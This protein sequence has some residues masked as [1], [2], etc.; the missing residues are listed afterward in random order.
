MSVSYHGLEGRMWAR[1]WPGDQN[2]HVV[3]SGVRVTLGV[4]V[5]LPSAETGQSGV[6]MV[7]DLQPFLQHRA[8]LGFQNHAAFCHRNFRESGISS[9]GC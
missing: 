9:P 3:V 6:G 1:H 5:F 4:E 8:G 7:D 2:S